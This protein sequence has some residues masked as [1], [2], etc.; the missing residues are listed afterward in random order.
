[1]F[2]D[3]RSKLWLLVL[4]IGGAFS[5]PV[6][7][8]SAGVIQNLTINDTANA[9]D[10]SIQ[11]SLT[12][13]D[14]QYGDRTTTWSVIDNAYYGWQFIRPAA[15][16]ASFTGSTLASFSVLTKA[17]IEIAWDT[18]AAAPS[19]LLANWSDTGFD[20]V[21][22]NITFRVYKRD[23]NAG[24]AI[25]LGPATGA[26]MYGIIVKDTGPVGFASL[27][28][29]GQNGTTGGA[30]GAT[31]TVSTLADL[32][33]QATSTAPLTIRIQGTIDMSPNGWGYKV[34]VKS[35]K[36]ILGLGTDA[37]LQFGGL[38][39]SDNEKNVIIRNL[40]IK[41]SFQSWDGKL[42]D[43]DAVTVQNGAHHV[44][45]D[46]C[47][48]THM[49]DGLI[50]IVKGADYVTVSNVK[51]INHNKTFAIGTD[52]YDNHPKVTA[53][54][55][56]F[57]G[58]NQRNPLSNNSLTHVFN[59]YYEGITSY[60]ANSRREA[61]VYVEANY[62]KNSVNI[63]DISDG[64]EGDIV[65]TADNVKDNATGRNETRGTAFTPSSYYVYIKD[66]AA[67][68]PANVVKMAGAGK[69]RK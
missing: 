65:F 55:N 64:N 13:G 15:D 11:Y 1:M 32:V 49:E 25:N 2:H 14:R 29:L 36:T 33:T 69:I 5:S 45:I 59:N 30:G 47:T 6:Y 16:S 3:M 37:T 23:V 18:R 4:T 22:N 57:A 68:L 24:T 39:V 42:G 56:Y 7:A 62:Y 19:W 52:D 53:Y 21:S 28:A 46:R 66:N 54:H 67:T 48:L 43:W 50:D 51:F 31:V 9:A 40:T 38:Q 20:L 58:T 26:A 8:V 35:N 27:N 60:G 44:W 17:Q 10:W 63:T 41:D 34:P 61:D 12:T